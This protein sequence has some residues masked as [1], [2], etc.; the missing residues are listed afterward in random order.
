MLSETR[1]SRFL[2]VVAILFLCSVVSYAQDATARPGWFS[3]AHD[4]QHTGI[5]SVAAQSLERIHWQVPVDL[6][7][8]LFGGEL[9]IHYGSPLV[10]SSNTVI[11]PVKTGANSFRIEAHKGSD[12]SLVWMEDSRYFTPPDP[13]M[14]SFAPVLTNN[15]LAF[16]DGA[17]TVTVREHPD[18]ARARESH[19][20]FYGENNLNADP[21]PYRKHVKINTPI[22]ADSSG[23]LFFGFVVDGPTPLGLQSGLARVGLDGE[24]TWV[25]AA[26]AANDPNITKVMMASA[27][28]LSRDEKSVYVAVNS[29]DF[30]FG[31][32]L[33]LDAHT[34]AT[35]SSVRL[36]DP[37]SGLDADLSDESSAS[38]TIGPD[39]DV[40]FG[41]LEDPFPDH[42]D[43]GWL[44]HFSSDLKQQ[45]LPGSFGWDDTAAVV[46]AS[47]VPSYSGPSTYLLMT[48][49]NN[50]ANVGGDGV[51]KIAVVD[52]NVSMPDP[53]LGNPVM[54]EVLTIVGPTPNTDLPGVRE[55]CIN[56]AAVDPITKS[57]MANSEDGHLYRWDLTTNTLSQSINLTAGIGEAYTPTVI[58]VDGTVYAINDA[59]LFALGH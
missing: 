9:F 2:S 28:A 52:P 45:K 44:L 42:N 49:Y 18:A 39:G 8:P 56:A 43:R 15:R 36:I 3:H 32:L 38:P 14:I 23:N 53:V 31:Y 17:G 46:P 26:F 50:Y 27:P 55:W 35:L 47:A 4:A 21:S 40:Y 7:P 24:G 33:Q 5:S 30:G 19:L 54:N 58:G 11:V 13:F 10:T 6:A 37:Q 59:I 41:V 1:T 20:V 48:K 51:N 57:V 34:L 29:F 25:T 12:G 22:T 16:P